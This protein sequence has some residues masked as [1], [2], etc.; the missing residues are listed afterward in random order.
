MFELDTRY[1]P[2]GW[3]FVY[4]FDYRRPSWS[5]IHPHWHT[6]IELLLVTYG[7]GAVISEGVTY[8]LKAGDVFVVNSERI[9]SIYSPAEMKYHCL[10]IDFEFC[11]QMGIPFDTHR[12]CEVISDE[13][14]CSLYNSIVDEFSSESPYNRPLA[15]K[16]AL[17]MLTY[18]YKNYTK[19]RVTDIKRAG[20]PSDTS[21]DYIKS[22]LEYIRLHSNE[23]LK[24]DDIAESVG[25][26]KHHLC[27]EFKKHTGET[28][29]YYVNALKMRSAT[30]LILHGIS[31]VDVAI[32][33]GYDN[34]S[35]FT[36]VYKRHIGETP[37][38]TARKAP[39]KSK[40]M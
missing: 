24:L 32:G 27:R 35:Y 38:E 6:N 25:I 9:H 1:R 5:T 23:K 18:L 13:T 8:K 39:K 22:A 17:E 33:L 14:L 3:P 29:I 40:D 31:P 15:M 16:N 30:R 36:Q 11:R 19:E 2:I 26:S 28:V 34:T 10:I 20:R 21:V 4:H 7:S 37:S 12:L